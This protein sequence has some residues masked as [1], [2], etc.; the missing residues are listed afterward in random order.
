MPAPGEKNEARRHAQ[1]AQQT[2]QTATYVVQTAADVSG[3]AARLGIEVLK[4]NN[5]AA[6]HLWQAST[7]IANQLTQRATDHLG[8]AFGISGEDAQNVLED[9][10]RNLDAVL[11]SAHA[12]ASAA[13]EFSCQWIETTQK[14]LEEA[15]GRSD[16]LARCRTPQEFFGM[17]AEL[18]RDN[19]HTVLHGTRRL[20]EISARA[21]QDATN[22][23]SE[24]IQAA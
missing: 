16:T 24:R 3:R 6:Q 11:E 5:E 7:Q 20:S 12:M 23:L 21:A 2:E 13:E 18:A 19:L 15:I 1:S 22:K 17:Q 8:R 14:V 9:S 10:S 4:R